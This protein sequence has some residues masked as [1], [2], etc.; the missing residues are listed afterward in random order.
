MVRERQRSVA[1]GVVGGGRM[2]VYILR[3]SWG[4]RD[5]KSLECECSQPL[6]S[7]ALKVRYT[8]SKVPFG[9]EGETRPGEWLTVELPQEQKASVVACTATTAFFLTAEGTVFTSGL[10][11]KGEMGMKGEEE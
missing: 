6:C 10:N 8:G 4:E 5:T 11:L 9:Q 3:V 2:N 7:A 1:E